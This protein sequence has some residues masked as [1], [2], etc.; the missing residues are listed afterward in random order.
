MA[1]YTADKLQIEIEASS[2]SA[3]NSVKRLSDALK[4]MG[5]SASKAESEVSPL[6]NTLK[7]L[8]STERMTSS[9]ANGVAYALDSM[10]IAAVATASGIGKLLKNIARLIGGGVK[11]GIKAIGKE[12]GG[13][14]APAKKSE[15]A[16]GKLFSSLK[17]ILFYRVIRT[18]IREI[19]QAFKEGIQNLYQYSQAVG[20]HFAPAMDRLATDFQ[21]LKNGMGALVAP[22]LEALAPA[23]DFL[24]DKFVAL[25][26]AI[27]IAFAAL[28]GKSFSAAVKVPKKFAEETDK[29][30]KSLKS[31]VL[32]FDE[33]NVINDN[34]AGAG[35]ASIDFEKMFEEVDVPTFDGLADALMQIATMIDDWIN[36]LIPKFDAFNAALREKLN[37]IIDALSTDGLRDK[38]KQIGTDLANAFNELTANFPWLEVGKALGL[39]FDLAVATLVGFIYNYDWQQL[40]NGLAQLIN[41]FISGVNWY[42]FGELMFAK[43]KITLEVL[44]GLLLRLNMPELAKAASDVVIGFFNSMV[45]TLKKI[46]WE[47]I[48]RQ[49]ADFLRNIKWSDVATACFEAIG[50]A[51]GAATAF[52]W[53]LIQ[54]AWKSVVQWW[55]DSAYEDGKFTF[56]GLLQGI[57][58]KID[59][60]GVWLTQNVF[61]PFIDAF[62]DVFGIHSPSTVMAEIGGYLIDGLF[63]GLANVG[64]RIS[65]WGSNF[66]SAIK[67]T[68][69]IHSPSTEMEEVG[70]YS[71]AGLEKGFSGVNV[72]TQMFAKEIENC[73]VATADFVTI[74]KN[75]ISDLSENATSKIK[76]VH[77]FYKVQL[78][79]AQ[80]HTKTACSNMTNAYN[81]MSNNSV[82]AI[83]RI[84]SAL[85]SIPTHITTVHT[86][87]EEHQSGGS[88]LASVPAYANGGFVDSGELF[89][90]RE[91][92]AEMV[93]AIGNRTAVAN[94]DQIVQGITNGVENA[95]ESQNA[96]LREQNALLSAILSKT[97][98][99]IDGKTLMTSVERAQ[100]NRGANIMAGGVML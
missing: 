49:V 23:I 27:G 12:I 65:M 13:L 60:I 91:A 97:G 48:G 90:A 3:E 6:K 81:T 34:G 9:G 36:G 33:L 14:V 51:F 93:G 25:A 43:F 96:L 41:G 78:D 24:I 54:D 73:K 66:I 59:S 21:Y 11:N 29:A 100:R 74:S 69:G 18:V 70:E 63:E 46:D 5:D 58:W 86:I 15:G 17:R 52:L 20:T 88:N 92:G 2:N 95:N 83:G 98:V 44:A 35:G 4:K 61:T 19:G 39:G 30:A 8:F 1:E 50:A 71:V 89:L 84:I 16:F 38:V 55:Y 37:Y 31:F 99:T 42:E 26:N 79:S 47:E 45:D 7:Q 40:G 22:L 62:K 32:G 53:G 75:E 10:R 87:I 28:T 76:E 77:D 67:N 72:I 64:N 82:S 56:E 85:N 94:N 68:L 80:A 57:A